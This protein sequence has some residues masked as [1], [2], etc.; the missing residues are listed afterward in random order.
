MANKPVE[1]NSQMI[2]FTIEYSVDVEE[3][4]EVNLS[5]L[6]EHARETGGAIVTSV[7]VRNKKS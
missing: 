1:K 6:L 3:S 2:V 7:E 4:M 5:G